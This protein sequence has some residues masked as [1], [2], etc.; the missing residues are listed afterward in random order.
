M[1]TGNEGETDGGQNGPSGSV[2]DAV[3]ILAGFAGQLSR[4]VL[5]PSRGETVEA[6]LQRNLL[7][8]PERARFLNELLV[9]IVPA[10]ANVDLW[11]AYLEGGRS[12]FGDKVLQKV[13]S[14]DEKPIQS[15]QRAGP[16]V[17]RQ[18]KKVAGLRA[19]R[20]LLDVQIRAEEDKQAYYQA[21][22]AAALQWFVTDELLK[23]TAGV[24]AMG[25]AWTVMRAISSF[26]SDEAVERETML[27]IGDEKQHEAARLRAERASETELMLGSLDFFCGYEP[28]EAE[29]RRALL[30]VARKFEVRRDE[31][32]GDGRRARSKRTAAER[33]RPE[34]QKDRRLVLDGLEAAA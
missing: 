28:Y 15:L 1:A 13:A 20:D 8:E 10:R 6:S 24:F 34:A 17:A 25:P 18:E 16:R 33:A 26:L 30:E 32:A 3:E 14:G 22:E 27:A 31:A 11:M 23:M 21:I 2:G 5:D 19:Q 7:S 4:R 9:Q 29:L 12:P